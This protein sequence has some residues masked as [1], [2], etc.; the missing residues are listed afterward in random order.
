M[1]LLLNGEQIP[2]SLIDSTSLT[3]LARSMT[4]VLL[5]NE[6]GWNLE[7]QFSLSE[8]VVKNV[9]CVPNTGKV[10]TAPNYSCVHWE[11]STPRVISSLRAL[12]ITPVVY[13]REGYVPVHIS[14]RK[15]RR[16]HC[17]TDRVL[18]AS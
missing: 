8:V 1:F 5:T 18:Y 13:A 4:M 16:P 2:P 7:L 9:Y 17:H 6:L 10:N 14:L 3:C 15:M 12:P 11:R